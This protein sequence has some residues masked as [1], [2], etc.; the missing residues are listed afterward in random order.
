MNKDEARIH[1]SDE[2]E[3]VKTSIPLKVTLFFVKHVPGCIVRT[4]LHIISFFFYV[5][6]GRARYEAKLYQ[7]QLK[8]FSAGR[9]PEKIKVLRQIDSFALCVIEKMYGWL[10]KYNFENIEY[11]H[12]DIDQILADLKAGKGVFLFTSHLG[13]MELLRSL[14]ENNKK[15]VGRDVPVF[16][17]M[18]T[19]V[20]AQFSSIL[21]SINS[22]VNYNIIEASEIGPDTMVTLIDA[23]EGGGMV[24][25][26]GDRTSSTNREKVLHQ[27]FLGREAAFPYG[28]F[29]IPFL[30]KVPVYYLFALRN[31]YKKGEPVYNFFIEKS[32]IDFTCTR[33]QRESCI[34]ACCAE[35]AQ[36]LEKFCLK[37]PYQWYNFFNFWNLDL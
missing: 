13:N 29:L 33:E 5:F 17:V 24:V 3:V 23:V 20:T 22:R 16:V 36:K 9:V 15:L 2:K 14:S 34:K 32:K 10:G 26:A 25:I 31:G 4:I 30:L 28:S 6:S 27:S 21:A 12:D 18:D 7:K 8:I 19:K 35:Y 1:W 37:F 11:Q